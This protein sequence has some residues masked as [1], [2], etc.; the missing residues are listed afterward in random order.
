MEFS[1]FLEVG[2]FWL[3]SIPWLIG[4]G[5]IFFIVG[6]VFGLLDN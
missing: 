6:A 1:S 3:Y 5:I 4:V 2:L